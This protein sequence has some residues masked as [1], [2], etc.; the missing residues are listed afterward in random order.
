MALALFLVRLSVP[1]QP[2]RRLQ[3]DRRAWFCRFSP[4]GRL[5][6]KNE[7]TIWLFRLPAYTA[8]WVRANVL[9]RRS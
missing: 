6:V 2:Y 5:L 1:L 4:N 8:L 3:P 7:E 9:R